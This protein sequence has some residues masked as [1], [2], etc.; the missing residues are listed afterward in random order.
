MI[1]MKKIIS[2]K[3]T[4]VIL[5]VLLIVSAPVVG[6]CQGGPG[7]PGGGGPDVPFDDDMNI[8]FLVTG[9]LFAAFVV[10]KK[11]RKKAVA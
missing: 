10:F 1:S 8:V 6:F 7:G 11:F 5:S 9:I 2:N 3:L 4:K